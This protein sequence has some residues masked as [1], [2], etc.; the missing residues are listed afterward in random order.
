MSK[1]AIANGFGNC[2]SSIVLPFLYE[3]INLRKGQLR[4][5]V[6]TLRKR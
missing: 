1:Q 4:A 2:A 3:F 6:R 5:T